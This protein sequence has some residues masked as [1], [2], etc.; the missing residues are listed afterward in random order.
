ML[1][2]P[3]NVM[4]YTGKSQ[5][6][7]QDTSAQNN[8]LGFKVVISL[9]SCLEDCSCHEVFSNNFFT[10]YDLLVYF[11]ETDMTASGTARENRLKKCSLMS[12]L[13]IMKMEHGVL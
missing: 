10:S 7:T 8:G 12:T 2:T 13:T 6:L 4:I 3:F 9:L 11:Q 5:Q 1:D